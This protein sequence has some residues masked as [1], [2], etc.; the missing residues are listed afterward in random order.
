MKKIPDVT[1][2]IL[3]GGAS[4]RFGSNKALAPIHSVPLIQHV[5]TP[6]E[7]LFHQQLLIT[8]TPET[9]EFLEW[10]V[11]G[12][13]YKKCGPLGGIHAALQTINTPKAFIVGC[14]MPLLNPVLIS[15]ICTLS[16]KWNVAL[17]WLEAG[18]EPLYG[19]Y[20]KDCLK[21]IEEN[22]QNK[23]FKIRTT[24]ESLKLRKIG[25]NEILELIGDLNTFHNINFDQ[26][27][28]IMTKQEDKVSNG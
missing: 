19:V 9:Y 4:A 25:Q 26:D 11:T 21:K 2:V 22:L 16:G 20:C 23:K 7:Q 27:L 8:N 12:D 18:P 13:V 6:L 14:D 15:Y 17:P 28:S 24:L 10:P 3:A 5:A 1:G